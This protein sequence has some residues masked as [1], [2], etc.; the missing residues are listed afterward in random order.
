MFDKTLG[1]AE[2]LK[3]S[4][5]RRDVHVYPLMSPRCCEPYLNPMKEPSSEL[6]KGVRLDAEESDDV[7]D[8]KTN[9]LPW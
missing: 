5:A 3:V 9:I 8:Y 4:L 6:I 2:C 1:E 7:H